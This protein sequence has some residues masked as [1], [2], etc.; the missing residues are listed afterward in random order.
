MV[1]DAALENVNVTV[2]T[3]DSLIE[4]T[5]NVLLY[6]TCVTDYTIASGDVSIC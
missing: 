4:W 5:H 1:F 6:P 3:M 2:N